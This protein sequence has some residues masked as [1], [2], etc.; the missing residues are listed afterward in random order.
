M[1]YY[2]LVLLADKWGTSEVSKKVLYVFVAQGAAKLQALKFRPGRVSN[3]GLPKTG[4][5]YTKS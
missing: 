2:A 1:C 4:D 3:P 5:Y